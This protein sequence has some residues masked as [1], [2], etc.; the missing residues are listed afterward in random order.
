MKLRF[1]KIREVKAPLRAHPTDAGVDFFVPTDLKANDIKNQGTQPPRVDSFVTF[2]DS[3]L[4]NDGSVR[5]FIRDGKITEFSMGPH[6]SILL[7]LGVKVSFDN[8]HAL[9]FFNKSGVAANK[10]LVVGSCVVDSE[11]Q[12][13]L[14]LNLN[15]ISNRTVS[16]NAGDKIIQGIILPVICAEVDECENEASLYSKESNR[17]SGGFGSTGN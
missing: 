11:Y 1:T 17:G 5:L 4:I 2:K 6:S 12:G 13:E 15:N 9:I 14:I 3:I 10:H 7:P 8:N 16:F